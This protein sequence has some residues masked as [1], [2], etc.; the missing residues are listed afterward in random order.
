MFLDTFS[1]SAIR[2]LWCT[3]WS[4]AEKLAV[5][6]V[7]KFIPIIPHTYQITMHLLTP[8]KLNAYLVFPLFSTAGL[9]KTW[10]NMHIGEDSG[11]HFTRALFIS[12]AYLRMVEERVRM[13][14]CNVLG[15]VEAYIRQASFTY[16]HSNSNSWTIFDEF[17]RATACNAKRIFAMAEVSVCLFVCR[18]S[19]CC[20]V[21][22]QR[23]WGA[24]N[25]HC[26][27][28]YSL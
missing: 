24:W 10:N 7:P 28:A 8:S 16:S 11:P 3:V 12:L 23:N 26:V 15:N 5:K 22:K 19:H 4:V 27:I 6:F 14:T 21:S 17:L 9:L 13:F 2:L 18:W 20:I 1:C 25:L